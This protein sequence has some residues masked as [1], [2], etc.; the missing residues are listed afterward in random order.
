M[1]DSITLTGLTARGFHGVFP[2]E[3]RDGQDF[4]T[5]VV[6][7]LDTTPAARADDLSLTVNYAQI[8]EAVLRVITGESFDLIESV[9]DRIARDV[10]DEQPVAAAVEVTVHKPHAPIEAD[11]ADV[12]VTVRR[13]RP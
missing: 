2:E 12:A 13:S 9:A 8:A 1:D 5:D 7:H 4:T 6:V 11:F 10:L 3:K